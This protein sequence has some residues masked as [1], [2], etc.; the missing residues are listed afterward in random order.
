MTY[1]GPSGLLPW[2][3]RKGKEAAWHM[4]CSIPLPGP[5]PCAEHSLPGRCSPGT[6]P[7][8]PRDGSMGPGWLWWAFL[9][10]AALGYPAHPSLHLLLEGGLVLPELPE[11]SL[12]LSP[13][14]EAPRALHS[15]SGCLV[16]CMLS[17]RQA[18]Q[19]AEP[20]WRALSD[21]QIRHF[22]QER[23]YA[24]PGIGR[25]TEAH[26]SVLYHCDKSLLTWGLGR[27]TPSLSWR[28]QV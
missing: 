16:L 1:D 26:V 4:P 23:T 9:A 27:H 11:T 20:Q 19:L 28:P 7:Q 12:G 3:W 24:R 5:G 25:Q 13:R 2:A 17:T 8:A 10:V 18:V 6:A 15:P 14:S 22:P 21:L